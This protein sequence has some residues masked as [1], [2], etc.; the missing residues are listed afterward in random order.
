M[1]IYITS[2][3]HIDHANII[4]FCNRPFADVS[5]MQ[6][7]LIQR[8]N[9]VVSKNDIVYNLGDFS[10]NEKSI[11]EYLKQLNGTIYLICGNHDRCHPKYGKKGEEAKLRYIQYGFAGVYQTLY[12]VNGF[13]LTHM[14]HSEEGHHGQKYMQY[15]PIDDGKTWVLCGHI[16]SSPEKR[17]RTRQIDC[18]IDGANYF[19][20][21]LDTLNVIR[22][23][24]SL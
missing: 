13:T 17:V 8:H 24:G 2:D 16:H 7:E 21:S 20:I 11:P 10:M 6:K 4:K 19:P 14:P 9:S 22:E 15:R 1:S 18:G 3:L 23:W 12:N 5:E